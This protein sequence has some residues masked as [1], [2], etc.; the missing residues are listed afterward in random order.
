MGLVDGA[1]WTILLRR[2]AWGVVAGF[3][4]VLLVT[5]LL[6]LLESLFQV[7]TDITLLELADLN[8]PI[9]RKLMLE[10]PGTYHHSLVVG[11][12]SEPGAEAVGGNPLLARVSAYYHDIGKIDKAEYYVENQSSA[13]MR[14]MN[15]LPSRP[16]IERSQMNTFGTNSD[17]CWRATSA[18]S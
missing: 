6:P 12:L 11:S 18:D 2:M 7:T 4:S 14:F 13:R 15:C 10:A 8:R 17:R 1:Q 3:G 5:L 16:G 9:L